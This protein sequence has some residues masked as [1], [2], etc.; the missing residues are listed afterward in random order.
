MH[1]RDIGGRKA[2]AGEPLALLVEYGT[3]A[4]GDCT[5]A[6]RRYQLQRH[7]IEREQHRCRAVANTAPRGCARE[8]SLMCSDA[9][10]EIVDQNDNVIEP[11]NETHGNSPRVVLAARTFSTPIAIAAVRCGMPSVFARDTIASKA[12]SRIWYSRRI[13]SSSSQNNCCRSCTHSK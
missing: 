5:I 8:Q 13:T 1:P 11:G 9:G 10:L 3:N 7:V 6:V 2:N 4:V 12:R